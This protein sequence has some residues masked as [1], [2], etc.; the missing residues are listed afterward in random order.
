MRALRWLIVGLVVLAATGASLA[1]AA[2]VR[3][4]YGV[5]IQAVY[6]R[7]GNPS[8]VANFTPNGGLAK[9][10]WSVCAPADPRVCKPVGGGAQGLTPGPTQAGTVF[11]A[12]ATYKGTTYTSISAQ[13]DGQVHAVHR[14]SLRGTPRVGSRVTPVGAIWRGGWRV[15]PTYHPQDG[16]QSG[17][18]AAAFDQLSV[19]ACRSRSG[20]HCLNLSPQARPGGATIAVRIGARFRGW[21]LFA[22]DQRL[23]GDTAFAAPGY[24]TP[25]DI[26]ALKP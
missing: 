5:A 4:H 13:W 14:P 17:G 8:L 26:P 2:Q 11:R 16:A 1:S 6:D 3:P 9:P 23:S 18:R 20:A 22:F 24:A 12:S 21:Y 15:D 7:H 25:E 19:E 10:H